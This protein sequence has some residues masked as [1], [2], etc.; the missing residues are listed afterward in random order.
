MNRGNLGITVK[1]NLGENGVANYSALNTALRHVINQ[2]HDIYADFITYGLIPE[3]KQ[4]AHHVVKYD[5]V[6][7]PAM[8]LESSSDGPKQYGCL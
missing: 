4:E 2:I 8:A 6:D 3:F 5:L 1:I 7:A